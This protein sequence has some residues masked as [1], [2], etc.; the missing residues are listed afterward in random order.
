VYLGC[1]FAV[2][3]TC[4]HFILFIIIIIIIFLVVL[5]GTFA[6]SVGLAVLEPS[7][8]GETADP[9]ATTLKIL[10]E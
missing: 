8:N 6:C 9:F 10:P 4:E 1:T 7:M 2:F 5:P 3:N